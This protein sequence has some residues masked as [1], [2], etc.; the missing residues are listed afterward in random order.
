MR[1]WKT[2]VTIRLE[3]AVAAIPEGT[4]L[5][6]PGAMPYTSSDRK[7]MSEFLRKVV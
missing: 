3:A 6:S 5:T 4:L 1:V 2:G 7:L